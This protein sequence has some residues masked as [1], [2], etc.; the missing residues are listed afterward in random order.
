MNTKLLNK[1]FVVF[2]T[3]FF[4]SSNIFGQIV[5]SKSIPNAIYKIQRK[6]GFKYGYE[7]YMRKQREKALRTFELT[8]INCDTIFVID[9]F[10]SYVGSWEEYIILK[11]NIYHYEFK[12]DK[13]VKINNVFDTMSEKIIK[14][15]LDWNTEGFL[16]WQ[17]TEANDNDF[18][19]AIQLI[20]VSPQKYSYSSY[21][22]YDNSF[23]DKSFSSGM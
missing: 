19:Q 4:C 3:L 17:T 7:V 23:Y 12:H 9:F 21:K 6:A 15:V 8:E 20:K 16:K 2:L 13:M 10:N 5:R 22:F 1:E 11:D 14:M 18:I